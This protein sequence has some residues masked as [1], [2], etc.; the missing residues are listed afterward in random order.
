[1][2]L[3]FE[4]WRNFVNEQ[5]EDEVSDYQRAIQI[6]DDFDA[7]PLETRVDID[8]DEDEDTGE[9]LYNAK[10]VLEAGELTDGGFSEEE[11][12]ERSVLE[13]LKILQ[14][15]LETVNLVLAGVNVYSGSDAMIV[16]E[17]QPSQPG[18]NN[19]QTFLNDV[20]LI[21]KE[22]K[23]GNIAQLDLPL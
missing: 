22:I 3:L 9:L 1:M 13:K 4:N 20:S 11:R 2:K 23:T 17:Y 6:V 21:S 16:I 14:Q 8:V 15:N 12:L 7:Q 19:L 10:I 18:I 5:I